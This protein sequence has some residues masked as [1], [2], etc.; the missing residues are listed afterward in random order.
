MPAKSSRAIDVAVL[1]MACRFPGCADYRRFWSALAAGENHV[2]PVPP[3]RWPADDFYSPDVGAAN[4][5]VSRWGGFLTRIDEF[6]HRFFGISP[7]EAKSM[8]PQ[9]RLLLEETWH[10]IRAEKRQG[11]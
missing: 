3:E 2:T 10:C 4:R 7:R 6:D 1:G 11:R 9:Q 8:D 5:S